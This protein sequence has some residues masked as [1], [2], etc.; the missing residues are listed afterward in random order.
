MIENILK[1]VL[2]DCC[3]S[4]QSLENEIVLECYEICRA[5]SPATI[6]QQNYVQLKIKSSFLWTSTVTDL[7]YW[8]KRDWTFLEGSAIITGHALCLLI[9]AK[10]QKLN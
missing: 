7:I 5:L 2:S 9:P 3:K 10:K 4:A 1:Q 6:A 8:N